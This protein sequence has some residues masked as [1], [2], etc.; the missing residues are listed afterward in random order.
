MKEEQIKVFKFNSTDIKKGLL[1][2]FRQETA[3]RSNDIYIRYR[4]PCGTDKDKDH[5]GCYPFGSRCEAVEK[6]LFSLGA[7]KGEEILIERFW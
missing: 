4:M 2:K 7:E 1:L 3:E 6:E 5:V